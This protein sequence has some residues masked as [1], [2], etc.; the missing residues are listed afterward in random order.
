MPKN[1]SVKNMACSNSSN[2]AEI[3]MPD[4]EE[5]V[6]SDILELTDQRSTISQTIS[7]KNPIPA[8]R[9]YVF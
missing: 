3:E 7:S 2:D 6:L 4:F 1:N 5:D 8:R 9:M